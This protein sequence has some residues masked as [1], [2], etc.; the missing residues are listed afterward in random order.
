MTVGLTQPAEAARTPYIRHPAGC[1]DG[2]ALV[3]YGPGSDPGST[4]VDVIF[5]RG[6]VTAQYNPQAR[7]YYFHKCPGCGFPGTVK[8]R[9]R[10]KVV[11]WPL[12][13]DL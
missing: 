11:E 1:K 12:H 5:A 6:I 2:K 7:L 13:G 3:G 9:S 10:E 4:K 8:Y